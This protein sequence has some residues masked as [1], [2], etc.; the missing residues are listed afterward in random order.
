[1]AYVIGGVC[2][3]MVGFIITEMFGFPISFVGLAIA[4]LGAMVF[5]K[6]LRGN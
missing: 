3:M 1:M 5:S 6:A 2:M 4:I